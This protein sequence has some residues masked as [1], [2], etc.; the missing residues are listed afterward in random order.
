MT[1]VYAKVKTILLTPQDGA[2]LRLH[3]PRASD[4]R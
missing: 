2:W 1:L 4:E 3:E